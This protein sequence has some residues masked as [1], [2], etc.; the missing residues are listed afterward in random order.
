MLAIRV[1]TRKVVADK[2]A[3]RTDTTP[4]V[5]AIAILSLLLTLPELVSAQEV[6]V[7]SKR[8]EPFISRIVING[9]ESFTDKDLKQL[10][11]TKEP[12]FFAVFKKPRVNREVLRRD[13][14]GLEA[15]YHSN[16]FLEARVELEKL[17]ILEDQAFADIIISVE[18]G[19]PTRVE[20]VDF[21]TGGVLR[22]QELAKGLHMRPGV[23]FN[24]SLINT[25]VYT[26]KR[27]HFEKGLLAVEV[28]DSVS[29]EG[30]RVAVF[31]RI[32]PGPVIKI[33]DIEIRGNRLTKDFIVEK[34]LVFKQGE[35]FRLAKAV[36]TQRNLFETGLFTEA[37]IIPEDLDIESQTVDIVV[38]VR[39]R[40]SAYFEFGFGVGN[41]LGS[42]VI[43]E[44]GDRNL[45]GTGRRLGLKA[46]YSVGIFEG[47]E[48]D[49]ESFD[50]RVKFYRY[51]LEFGQRHF[52]GTKVF[53]GF[54]AFLE[55]D[56]TVE[57]IVVRSRG[58]AVGGVRHLSPRTDVV[59][60]LSDA[61]IKR[62]VPDVGA[63]KSTTRLIA[64]TISHDT[65][66]FILD[67]HRGGYRDLRLEIAGGILGGENDF[68]TA[69]TA[70]Q[71]YWGIGR[72][73]TFAIR[74]RVGYADAY[75]SSK[76]RGVPVENRYF[77]GG[78][79]SVRGYRENSL[80]PT[81][82]IET[83]T[84]ELEETAVGGEFLLVTNAELRFPLPL[85]SRFRFSAA[86]FFDGGNSWR[87]IE[88]VDLRDFRP[89]ADREEV[90]EKDFRYSVGFGIRYNTPVGPIR[91]DMGFPI[92]R[93]ES[94]DRYRLHLSLGQIF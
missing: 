24:P 94:T 57:P 46:E 69:N 27:K 10:M 15:F 68:Y 4:W 89:F 8:K 90:A 77:T 83:S 14:A 65:R 16:G 12:S 79:N 50:P 87:D 92:K 22:A 29:V 42:R 35:A 61:R 75:G 60:R 26:I 73:T 72:S 41:V 6:D 13:I 49:F 18:E 2:T 47:G 85:L 84:G 48:F 62:E 28:D 67:P 38:R 64:S 80:G 39:E 53:L 91:L 76:E 43:G 30:K 59:L 9:N 21:E 81:E 23:P 32:T 82:E 40:K 17:R 55:K 11:T 36:E 3:L 37:E 71:K 20:R 19:E 66:D 31:Y 54:N 88:S 51:D 78:G 34:E 74:G 58:F 44:W 56:A 5:C 86:T 33:R 25:D 45:F 63:E 7:S 93:D 1:S 70:L 52:L